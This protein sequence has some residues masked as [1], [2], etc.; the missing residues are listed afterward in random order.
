MSLPDELEDLWK[1]VDGTAREAA[2]MELQFFRLLKRLLPE[3]SRTT[4]LSFTPRYW[5]TR[6][7]DGDFYIG[8]CGAA[9]LKLHPEVGLASWI[10]LGRVTYVARLDR[11]LSAPP[12][13]PR[14]GA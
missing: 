4:T 11:R 12:A 1:E 10:S 8:D 14:E 3:R 2:A 9:L 6:S 7:S 5:S 13:K